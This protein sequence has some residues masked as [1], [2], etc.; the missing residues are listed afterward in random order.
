MGLPF[1][2]YLL[3]LSSTTF[4]GTF[5]PVAPLILFGRLCPGVREVLF[6]VALHD[7]DFIVQKSG[8]AVPC[9]GDQCLF[10]REI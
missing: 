8:R 7:G 3:H 1:R 5:R 10:F 6:G 4:R 9:V 2:M